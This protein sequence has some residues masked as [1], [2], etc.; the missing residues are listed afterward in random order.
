MLRRPTLRRARPYPKQICLLQICCLLACACIASPLLAQANPADAPASIPAGALTSPPQPEAV[1]PETTPAYSQISAS[2]AHAAS[3]A[4]IAGTKQVE[5]KDL[6]S[7][8]LSFQRAAQLNPGNRDY[9]LALVIAKESRTSQLVRQAAVALQSGDSTKSDALLAEA[10]KL[11]PDDPIVAQHFGTAPQPAAQKAILPASFIASTLGSPVKLIAKPGTHSFHTQKDARG[12]LQEIY[13]AYGITVSF[14]SSVP[15]GAN[16]AFD[17]DDVSFDDAVRIALEVTHT[18]AVPVQ[19]KQV[20][21]I[22]DQPEYRQEF[23]PLAEETIYLPGYTQEQMTD[24]A[25]VARNIFDVKQVTASSSSGFM[26]LRGDVDSLKLVNAT[27]ADMLDGGTDILFDVSLYEISTA[28]TNAVGAV[29]PSSAGVFSIAAEAD[30]LISSNATILNQA[31]SSGLLTLTGSPLQNL[32][33]EIEFLIGAGVVTSTQFSGFIGT[34][35]GG[36][37]YAGLYLGSNSSFKLALNS[38][39]SR[40]LDAV[41]IRA[42]NGQPVNFRAGSRYPVITGTY[43]SGVSSS[44][45]SQLSGLNVNGTSVSSLLAGLLSSTQASVPQFQFEDLGI[46]LKMTPT[47]QHGG[48]VSLKLDLKIEALGGTSI[49][50]IPI[51]N[52]RTLTSTITVPEGKTAMLAQLV[53]KNEIRSIDGLPGISELP[54]FQGTDKEKEVDT[55]EFLL[56]ITPHV[57]RS[58]SDRSSSKRLAALHTQPAQ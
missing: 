47:V 13:T 6:G 44:L 2:D 57:V 8:V 35:G 53:S 40:L 4:Y 34:F 20:L 17:I 36:L 28:K 24:L 21:L 5:R 12:L 19:P 14:D 55:D 27:Y 45:A 33:T 3:E 49:N 54:G 11:T 41:Q 52:N 22:K 10:Y 42:G 16:I 38:T 29:L 30:S 48:D 26:L 9:A 25:N 32:I 46:T 56:T 50:N 1:A 37:A 43:S 23:Q 15:T 31:I 18:F 7:A 51:L 39:E 58:G